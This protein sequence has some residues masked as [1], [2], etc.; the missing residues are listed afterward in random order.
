MHAAVMI[1]LSPSL[2]PFLSLS[3]FLSL[4][5]LSSCKSE[6][7]YKPFRAYR[8]MGQPMQLSQAYCLQ[9]KDRGKIVH[10]IGHAIG[11][12]HEQQRPDRDDYVEILWDNLIDTREIRSDYEIKTGAHSTGTKY[13]YKSI[14]HY[15][16]TVNTV[17]GNA[18]MIIKD[19]R[20]TDIVGTR[21]QPSSTDYR[22]AN[23]FY[24]CTDDGKI[25]Y[26]VS[27][28]VCEC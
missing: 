21:N 13:D 15:S 26:N 23:L 11:F 14:M 2:P 19:E 25:V 4:P 17:N 6:V 12:Y 22:Q 16:P 18:T 24:S 7:G 27:L 28:C 5:S 10:E 1:T 9:A 20:F 3:L 8:G